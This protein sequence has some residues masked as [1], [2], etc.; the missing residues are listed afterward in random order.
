MAARGTTSS[1][2]RPR[3][4][5]RTRGNES[6][7]IDFAEAEPAQALRVERAS[8]P[9]AAKS[10]GISVAHRRKLVAFNNRQP[11]DVYSELVA[12]SSPKPSSISKNGSMLTEEKLASLNF[13]TQA[14]FA[15]GLPQRQAS[16]ESMGV[17]GF[18]DDGVDSVALLQ[19]ESARGRQDGSHGD[20]KH[21]NRVTL[22]ERNRLL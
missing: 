20:G 9:P 18:D 10:P 6:T 11:H 4:G 19:N 3:L 17:M 22:Q 5:T 14:N 16:G 7:V 1:W 13:R 12:V 2:A 8:L 15:K 21:M